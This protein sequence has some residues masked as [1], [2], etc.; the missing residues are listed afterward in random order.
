ML[1]I[2]FDLDGT[3][4]DTAPDLISTLNII[5]AREGMPPVDANRRLTRTT[6][7]IGQ[8][9]TQLYD[10][11]S[12]VVATIDPL[13]LRTSYGYD[14]ASN[15]I[16]TIN[17]LGQITTSVFD[18]ANRLVAQVDPLGDRTSFGMIVA[19]NPIRT[20]TRFRRLRRVCSTPTTAWLRRSTPW[21]PHQLRLRHAEA[22]RSARPTRWFQLDQRV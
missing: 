7:P 17:P 20:T 8:I 16:R 6:S 22:V 21:E 15:L 5:L 14:A 19:W 18:L 3:L 13:G 9:A 11:N 4:I 1:T 10:L 2:V 12:R